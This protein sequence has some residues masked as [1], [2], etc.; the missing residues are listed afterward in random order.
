[1]TRN[2][3]GTYCSDVLRPSAP[4]FHR[5]RDQLLHALELGG[6]GRPIVLADDVVAQTAGAD[7]R[8]DVDRRVRS[9]FEPAEIVAERPPVLRDAEVRRVG[10]ASGTSRSFTGAIDDPSPVTSVVTPCRI[11][12]AARPSTRHV[13]FGL[14]RAD[15]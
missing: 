3:S 14:A 9:L 15:R 1:L 5:L 8:G 2:R 6:G 11:L 12:L 13:E 10:R 7:E 4:C